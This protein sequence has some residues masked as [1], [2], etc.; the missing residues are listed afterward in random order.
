MPATLESPSLFTQALQTFQ[1][2]GAQTEKEAMNLIGAL[3][4]RV[5][6]GSPIPVYDYQSITYYGSTNNPH[7]I[8]YKIGGSGGTTVATQTLTYVDDA[9]A[10]NDKVETITIV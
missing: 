4:S 3:L 8:T 2:K 7:V 5:S 6:G 1:C 10:D 9:V